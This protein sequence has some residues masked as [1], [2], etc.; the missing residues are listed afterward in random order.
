MS[1][2]RQ[3]C[4]TI[5]TATTLNHQITWKQH[6]FTIRSEASIRGALM[7]V[8]GIAAMIGMFGVYFG[9][10]FLPWRTVSLICCSVQISA[11]IGAIFVSSWSTSRWRICPMLLR[12]VASYH[13]FQKTPK[14]DR[15]SCPHPKIP[16]APVWLLSRNRSADAQT[17][18]QRLRGSVSRQ[19]VAAEFEQM[20]QVSKVSAA[21]QPCIDE[22][23]QCAH[24]ATSTWAQKLG[25]VTRKRTLKP[26]VLIVVL[27][28]MM[29]FSAVFAMRPYL[30]PILNAHGIALDANLVTVVFG[31][32]G[33]IAN[34]LIVTCVRWLG[35][36]AIYLHS[37][38]AYCLSCF[39]LGAL[40]ENG[41][42]TDIIPSL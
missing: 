22:R 33:L 7:S 15:F 32:L 20:A 11:I 18:L 28:F 31:V 27:C 42:V 13:T 24:L 35:K 9:G 38:A 8:A 16:E 29:Q 21:C 41:N 6:F 25:D 34:L 12:F 1:V 36:R 4:P 2:P 14:N 19:A 40:Q 37:M 26:F 3:F 39:G 30:V 10:S 23:R 5:S 17:T